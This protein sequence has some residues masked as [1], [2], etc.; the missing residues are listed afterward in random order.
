[1]V[2][3]A[4]TSFLLSLY[5][6]DAHHATAVSLLKRRKVVLPFTP[7]QRHE[8]RNAVRL[9]VYR[10][11]ISKPEHDAVLQA[12]DTDADS[13]FLL[14]TGIAWDAVFAEAE[15][16]SAAHTGRLGNRGMDILHVA[17]ARALGATEFF[18]FDHRQKS[19]AERA[20]MKVRP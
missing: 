4:D 9:Q 15:A 10:K 14:V 19:L 1:M 6:A 18:T 16:L 13:G 7:L 12:I 3:Y 5:T 2:V 17:A 8:L 20:E 11:D